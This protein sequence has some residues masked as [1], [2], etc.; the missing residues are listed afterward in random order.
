M[1]PQSSP[2]RQ[3]APSHFVHGNYGMLVALSSLT[4]LA[5]WFVSQQLAHEGRGLHLGLF[6]LGSLGY[7]L[8]CSGVF[9]SWYCRRGMPV[10]FI[11][12]FVWLALMYY[13]AWS[14]GPIWLM[15]LPLASQAIL[16]LS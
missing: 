11:H 8:T 2:S 4:L 14:A 3:L 13:P 15:M 10:Y 7:F 5:T 6:F 9:N 12:Q 1:P 16:L